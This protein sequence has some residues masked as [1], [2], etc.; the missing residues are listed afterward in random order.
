MEEAEPLPLL[1]STGEEGAGP[2]DV[3]ERVPS[4]REEPLEWGAWPEPCLGAG[5]FA[6][7]VVVVVAWSFG[8]GAGQAPE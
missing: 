1:L 5:V 6:S 2:G 7:V 4:V 8:E 3:C